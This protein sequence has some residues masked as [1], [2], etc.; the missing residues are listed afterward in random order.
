MEQDREK[1]QIE[2]SEKQQYFFGS[3]IVESFFWS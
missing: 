1:N 2:N 3:F